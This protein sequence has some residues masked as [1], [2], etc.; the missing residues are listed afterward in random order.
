LETEVGRRPGLSDPQ[1]RMNPVHVAGLGHPH[2]KG[3]Q[4]EHGGEVCV[5]KEDPQA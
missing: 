1:T 2:A 3:E 4:E 5:E